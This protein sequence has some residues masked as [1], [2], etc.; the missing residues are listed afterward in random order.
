[1]NG[2]P[3][4]L[5]SRPGNQTGDWLKAVCSDPSSTTETCVSYVWGV[6]DALTRWPPTDLKP[7][8]I[9]GMSYGAIADGVRSHIASISDTDAARTDAVS[10]VRRA[11][12][13]RFSC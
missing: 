12:S 2:F 3:L 5:R 6:I 1:M 4:A 7:F 13:A 8:C 10:L 9:S 11:V